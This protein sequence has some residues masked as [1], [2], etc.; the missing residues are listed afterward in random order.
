M[1]NRIKV[2]A[3]QHRRFKAKQA[4]LVEQ[5]RA[6][7]EELHNAFG[8]GEVAGASSN[9]TLE[10]IGQD[11]Y[12]YGYLGYGFSGLT[13]C[14]RT[15][16]DDL[17]DAHHGVP[18]EAR[19]YSVKP[20]ANCPP[21]WLERLL[22]EEILASLLKNIGDRLDEKEGRV[23]SS[24]SALRTMLASESAKLDA[25]MAES[26]KQMGNETLKRIWDEAL[27]ASHLH[28]AD[29]LTRSS[30]FLESVCAA[31]LRERR[32]ALPRDKSMSPLLDECVKCLDWPEKDAL[33]DA[34]Q[35]FAGVKSI[36]G[37]IGSLR[38]HFG[39][40]HGASGHLPPLEA[41][42]ATLAKNSSAAVAIF[43][44]SRHMEGARASPGSETV[45]DRP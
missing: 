12:V 45:K 7:E 15:T 25:G 29:G 9:V 37:G 41:S 18:D 21:E 13:A 3:A 30:S 16:D 6:L 43:L 1:D 14:H 40:A 38:T 35:L 33:S 32:V 11:E 28:T 39:T 8:E 42:W 26:L 24:L 34:K 23:D 36:C 27:D 4:E 10:Q 17:A 22:D 44:I 31:I 5:A 20:L 2:L 19:S